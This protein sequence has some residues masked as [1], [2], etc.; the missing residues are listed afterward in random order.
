MNEPDPVFEAVNADDLRKR[1]D[2][3]SV[4]LARVEEICQKYQRE[5][6]SYQHA[7]NT[8]QKAETVIC[9]YRLI[10]AKPTKDMKMVS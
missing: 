7:N 3:L 6:C 1:V 9:Q 2:R 8:A 4:E 5:Q 10:T